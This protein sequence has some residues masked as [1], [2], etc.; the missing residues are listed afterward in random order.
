MNRYDQFTT[1]VDTQET[2]LSVSNVNTANFGKLYS[3]YLDG[4]VYAQPLYVSSLEVPGKGIHNVVFIATMNDKLYAF[5][6][7]RPGARGNAGNQQSG[8]SC[9]S[10]GTYER[11]RPIC[12]AV[13]QSANR[14]WRGRR[15]GELLDPVA[16]ATGSVASHGSPGGALTISSHGKTPGTGVLWATV[17]LDRSA[18]DGNTPGVLRAFNAE[19]LNEIWNSERQPDRDRLATLVKFVPPLVA[20]SRVYVPTYDNAV[21]V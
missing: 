4:G 7:D 15:K 12:P 13:T 10:R 19:T 16:V 1:G 9:L 8:R 5:D 18:D 17:S 2:V 21:N 20:A 11:E 6:A 3:L 14:L